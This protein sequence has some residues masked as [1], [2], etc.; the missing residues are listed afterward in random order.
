MMLGRFTFRTGQKN[1]MQL[2]SQYALA[3][4]HERQRRTRRLSRRNNGTPDQP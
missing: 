2:E 3:E 1:K 4:T